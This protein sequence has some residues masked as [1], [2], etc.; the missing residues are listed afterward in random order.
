MWMDRDQFEDLML[1]DQRTFSR[2]AKIFM[3]SKD[4][5]LKSFLDW[6]WEKYLDGIQPNSN[7]M[8][9]R[10]DWDP[11]DTV[12]YRNPEKNRGRATNFIL[13]VH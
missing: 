1:G 10:L 6:C 7:S 11:S 13:E 12:F 4:T 5:H 2:F 8:G 9:Q 3:D